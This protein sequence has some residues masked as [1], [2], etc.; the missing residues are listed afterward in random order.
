MKHKS[1][2][3]GIL[4][5]LGLLAVSCASKQAVKAKANTVSGIVQLVG[6]DPFTTVAIHG[7]DGKVYRIVAPKGIENRLRKLQGKRVV[8]EYSSMTT[9]V[10]GP[11]V[12]VTSFEE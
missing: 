7:S 12:S 3:F 6:N 9:T 5:L 4:L 2:V 11:V 8:V 1:I 10:E